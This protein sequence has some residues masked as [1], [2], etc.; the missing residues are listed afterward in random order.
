[1]SRLQEDLPVFFNLLKTVGETPEVK[2][3]LNPV[4]FHLTNLANKPY[5]K[6]GF[7]VDTQ[8]DDDDQ[9]LFL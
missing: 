9:N 2:E 8:D 5:G 3:G 6:S 4:L 7:V 1:M